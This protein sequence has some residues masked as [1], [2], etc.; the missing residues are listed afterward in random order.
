[1]RIGS[2]DYK[3]INLPVEFEVDDLEVTITYKILKNKGDCDVPNSIRQ[4]DIKKIAEKKLAKADFVVTR[5]L[6]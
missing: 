6:C 3:P 4:I 5:C 2:E 1:M